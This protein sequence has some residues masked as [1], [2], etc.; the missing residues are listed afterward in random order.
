MF[1]SHIGFYASNI[2]ISESI[3]K[4]L[5]KLNRSVSLDHGKDMRNQI[6]KYGISL[7]AVNFHTS[8]QSSMKSKEIWDFREIIQGMTDKDEVIKE[9]TS[10]SGIS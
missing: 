6:K 9:E 5:P 8:S 4:Q 10:N 7:E 2:K 3:N 1:C